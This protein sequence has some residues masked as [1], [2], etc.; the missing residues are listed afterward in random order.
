MP[1]FTYGN[2]FTTNFEFSQAKNA[3]SSQNQ[4]NLTVVYL[5]GLCSDPRGSKPEALKSFCLDAGCHF[6][7]FELAGHGSD[8]D[9]FQK[10]D[11]NIWKGQLLEVIDHLVQGD[12]ILAG[13]SLGGWL[14]LVGARERPERVRGVITLAA[15]CDLDADLY[16]YALSDE[17][18][19]AVE[20]GENIYLG[21]PEFNYVFTAA[22]IKAYQANAMLQAPI[23]VFCP[24]HLLQGRKDASLEWHKVFK[25]ADLLETDKVVVKILK[26]SA[27]R[28][29]EPESLEEFRRSL[30]DLLKIN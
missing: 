23:P 29:A 13:S 9:N 3:N 1:Q 19:A 15:A 7:R 20:R 22:Q 27:H 18:K 30:E 2:Q 11:F 24:V 26:N 12:I 10:T 17:Q 4:R 8:K 28:L 16:K 14:S 5:H 21:T 6:F 25:I